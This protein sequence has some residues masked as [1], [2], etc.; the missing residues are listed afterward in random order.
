[1]TRGDLDGALKMHLG[2]LN[3]ADEMQDLDSRGHILFSCA[4]IRIKQNQERGYAAEGETETIL[5]EFTESLKIFMQ[6]GRADA[7]GA[8]G[9]SFGQF[10]IAIGLEDA[11]R[12]VLKPA[13]EA[14]AK[15]G[16]Q[17][18]LDAVNQLLKTLDEEA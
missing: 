15:L 7:I 11:A 14:F 18:Y 3:F 13:A 1:M 8:V 6:L 16:L 12:E 17:E 4:Q 9:F 2:R 10:L 5:A